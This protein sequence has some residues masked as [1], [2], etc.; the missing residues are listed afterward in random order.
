MAE[1]VAKE[2]EVVGEEAVVEEEKA[3]PEPSFLY[4]HPSV[5]T[6]FLETKL[7]TYVVLFVANVYDSVVQVRCSSAGEQKRHDTY[8]PFLGT[9]NQVYLFVHEVRHDPVVAQSII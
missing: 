6:I 8:G 4:N 7:R 2:E 5:L 3:G 1:A 9:R